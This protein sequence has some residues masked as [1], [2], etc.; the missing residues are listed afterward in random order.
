VAKAQL[1][2]PANGDHQGLKAR[3]AHPVP[4]DQRVPR[5]TPALPRQFASSLERIAFAAKTTKS[6]LVLFARAVRP[7]E[8]SARPLVRQQPLYVYAGERISWRTTG[9]ASTIA[10]LRDAP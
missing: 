5:V 7:T 8:G 4:P 10:R 3:L 1:D 9:P 6:W 2:P